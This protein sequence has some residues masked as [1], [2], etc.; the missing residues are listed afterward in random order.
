MAEKKAKVSKEAKTE[1]KAAEK[2]AVVTAKVYDVLQRPIIS[3]KAAKLAE[4][5]G[6]AFEVAPAATKKEIA[7]AILAVYGVEPVKINVVN[8][9]GKVKSFRGKRKGT[10]RAVKKA[11]I[12]LPKGHTV[13]VLAESA[14]K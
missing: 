9:K 2:K 1:K 14:K 13:D 4:T 7:N 3:E 11:Y 6:L 8:V 12:T 10:Q 5:N